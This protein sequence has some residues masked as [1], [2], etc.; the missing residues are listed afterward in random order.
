MYIEFT[1]YE[2][3]KIILGMCTKFE[4]NQNQL[5]QQSLVISK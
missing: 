3:I 4:S 5:F 1:K 2:F